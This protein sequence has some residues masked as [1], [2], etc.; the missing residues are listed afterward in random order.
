LSCKEQTKIKKSRIDKI[1]AEMIES[2][3]GC[4]LCG[5]K[6]PRFV[7]RFQNQRFVVDICSYTGQVRGLLCID[8]RMLVKLADEDP[9]KLRNLLNYLEKDLKVFEDGI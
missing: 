4:E 6:E 7:G 2:K 8:C 9:E 1:R 3:G 5:I